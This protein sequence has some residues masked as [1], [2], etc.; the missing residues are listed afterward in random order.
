[1]KGKTTGH[2]PLTLLGI[3][4]A[5]IGYWGPWVNHKAAA[6]VLSG[7]DMSEYVK[8]LAEVK[9]G[10]K[11]VVRE[12]FYLPLLAAAL[13]L[14]LLSAD[15]R[16]NYSLWMRRL[17][18]I[19][20]IALALIVLPAYPFI[21]QAPASAEFRW[22]FASSVLCLL[23]IIG[24]RFHRFSSPVTAWLVIGFALVGIVPPLWQFFSIRGAISRVY[25]RPV[26]LGWGLGLTAAGFLIVA[27]KE[28]ASLLTKRN[29][30]LAE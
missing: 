28:A 5:L 25:G 30:S 20:A 12:L 11:P 24:C 7:L 9:Q 27:L 13:C 21:L 3:V 2:L 19:A 14:A 22:Q 26:E 4:L 18:L 10:T 29:D 16:A 23:F 17:M 8:F 15:E 1:M 6:L